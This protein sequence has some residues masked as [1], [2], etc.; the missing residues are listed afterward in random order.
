MNAENYLRNVKVINIWHFRNLLQICS[1]RFTFLKEIAKLAYSLGTF[2]YF[3]WAPERRREIFMHWINA[4]R[5]FVDS[6]LYWFCILCFLHADFLLFDPNLRGN[7]RLRRIK[8][9]VLIYYIRFI[10]CL[11]I[12]MISI[13][14]SD[15]YE[16]LVIPL[17]A[18]F[19]FI[20]FF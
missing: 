7:L 17:N 4:L 10:N 16:F 5:G 8:C 20:I 13:C 12:P 1:S 9:S 18:F 2:F 3:P 19:I 6:S 15:N 14:Y 11:G